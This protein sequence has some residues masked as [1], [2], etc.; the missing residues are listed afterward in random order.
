MTAAKTW[1][2]ALCALAA[3]LAASSAGCR[4]EEV[5]HARVPKEQEAVAAPGGGPM[6][7]GPAAGGPMAGDVPAPPRPSGAGAL[8][9]SLPKGWTETGGGGMRYATL[10][11]PGEGRIDVSVVVLPG[12]AGGEL[13]NVNRW[14]GQI[15]LPALD[16]ASLAA[17]R[18]EVATKAGKVSLYDFEAGGQAKTRMIAGL[19]ETPD[20]NTWFLKM[21]GDAGPVAASRAGF[22]HLLE[23]LHLD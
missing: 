15:G 2:P 10:K 13:A 23:T 16:E 1:K 5:V 14:R 8:K 6:A 7:G 21:V 18:R 19:L 4:R 20:G 22:V 12:V 9:W 3:A 17:A 11:P